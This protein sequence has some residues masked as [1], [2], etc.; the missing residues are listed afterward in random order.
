MGKEVGRHL[1]AWCSIMDGKIRES[2]DEVLR[3][4]PTREKETS[5]EGGKTRYKYVRGWKNFEE[6]GTGG[7][8][9][10]GNQ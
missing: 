7:G 8:A 10:R 5:T 4:K 1:P 9:N 3:L 6:K 2:G